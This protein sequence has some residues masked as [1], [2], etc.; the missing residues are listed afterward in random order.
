MGDAGS[1][2]GSPIFFAIVKIAIIQHIDG[3]GIYRH[4]LTAQAQVIDKQLAGAIFA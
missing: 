2:P 3:V 4:R 1:S